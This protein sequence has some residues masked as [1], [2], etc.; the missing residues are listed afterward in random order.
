MGLFKKSH[1]MD[2]LSAHPLRQGWGERS[3]LALIDVDP[4]FIEY[5]RTKPQIPKRGHVVH[6]ALI[7]SGND[8]LAFYDNQHVGRLDPDKAKEYI[9]EFRTLA[10]RK[11]FGL[12]FAGIRPAGAKSS[13]YVDLYY[14]KGVNIRDEPNGISRGILFINP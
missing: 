4:A 7:L 9:P 14:P 8:V 3:G 12:T 13:H 1:P 10:A 6:I 11:K 2:G 5:A